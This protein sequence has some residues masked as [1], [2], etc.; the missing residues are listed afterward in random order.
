MGNLRTL[1]K[2]LYDAG[3][4]LEEKGQSR[5]LSFTGRLRIREP[6]PR[7]SSLLREAA[8]VLKA[9]VAR[10]QGKGRGL[11]GRCDFWSEALSR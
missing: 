9:T 1:I 4:Y 10:A 11:L 5:A 7:P 3:L 6:R 2:P 8:L